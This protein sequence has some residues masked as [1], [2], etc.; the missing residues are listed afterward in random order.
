M[1][2]GSLSQLSSSY[3]RIIESTLKRVHEAGLLRDVPAGSEV[4]DE[5]GCRWRAAVERELTAMSGRGHH[6]PS[7]LPPEEMAK[8]SGITRSLKDAKPLRPM[9]GVSF[10]E[11]FELPQA[12]SVLPG[13]KRGAGGFIASQVDSPDAPAITGRAAQ[14]TSV[15]SS[16]GVG[17]R[18]SDLAVASHKR[19]RTTGIEERNL[20]SSVAQRGAAGAQTSGDADSDDEF[21]G[22]FDGA[23]V[24]ASGSRQLEADGSTDGAVVPA[25][26]EAVGASLVEQ[27]AS[28]LLEDIAAEESSEGSE[29]DSDLDDPEFMRQFEFPD[30]KNTFLVELK[31]VNRSSKKRWSIQMGRGVLTIDGKECLISSGRGELTLDATYEGD[32]QTDPNVP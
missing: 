19:A 11:E 12:Q 5:L 1:S 2:C 25:G 29:L 16:S 10:A 23:E 13:T 26:A 17:A 20:A 30:I 15:G 24:I 28:G 6:L 9:D 3:S 4:V 7:L 18:S 32:A 21:D 14:G 22:C 27:G 8:P 31:R